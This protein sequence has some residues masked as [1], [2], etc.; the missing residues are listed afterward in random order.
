M[1]NKTKATQSVVGLNLDGISSHGGSTLIEDNLPSLQNIK[2]L[3]EDDKT[4]LI[5][6]L[7]VNYDYGP[8]QSDVGES[9][10]SPSMRMHKF[11][12]KRHQSK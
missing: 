11:L 3:P 2:N 9:F 5:N 7:K 10:Q 1:R 6:K 8:V 12:S 4:S